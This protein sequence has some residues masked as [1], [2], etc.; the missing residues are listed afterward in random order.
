MPLYYKM[1]EVIINGNHPD[2]IA[3]SIEEKLGTTYKEK[4]GGAI[5]H[6]KNGTGSGTIRYIQIDRGITFISWDIYINE[7]IHL[8]FKN[9]NYP[10]I[11]F[12]Y[13]LEGSIGYKKDE[14]EQELKP[15]QNCIFAN[16][17]PEFT[18]LNISCG[19]LKCNFLVLETGNYR[20]KKNYNI[21]SFSKQLQ[22]F[23]NSQIHPS[24]NHFG[25]L[26]LKIADTLECIR[27]G[28]EGNDI[29]NIA[30]EGHIQL[31]LAQHLE[32]HLDYEKQLIL[33]NLITV[34]D[35]NK[36]YQ[37]TFYIQENLSDKITV[38]SLVNISGLNANKLQYCFRMLF[39][40]SVNAYIREKKLELGLESLRNNEYTISEIVYRIGWKSKSYFS[41]IFAEKYG[42]LPVEFRK[43]HNNIVNKGKKK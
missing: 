2:S 35:V 16:S 43:M 42:M 41:K 19:K 28:F 9:E 14:L 4:W 31:L 38:T 7:E 39:G 36:I 8:L 37:L 34:K 10:L 33:P 12:T 27:K 26:N 6:M 29:Q 22:P 32:T 15:Y 30:I 21:S 5:L 20:Q 11:L 13:L 40:L 25:Y 3:I 17:T 18:Q 24:F 23:F 1:K